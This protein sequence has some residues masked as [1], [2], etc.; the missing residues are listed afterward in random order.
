MTMT[1]D[2]HTPHHLPPATRHST[3]RSLWRGSLILGLISV[4]LVLAAQV[5][6]VGLKEQEQVTAP[7]DLWMDLL[8]GPPLVP[9]FNQAARG[10]DIA[11][12]DHW[13]QIS[14]L[15]G[16]SAGRKMVVF[17][18]AKEAEEQLPGLADQID[19]V[20]Y[21][22]EHGPGTPED[23]KADPV[24][25]IQRMR[26]LADAHGLVLALGPDHSFALSHGAAMAPYVDIF[27]LQIQQQ[28]TNPPVVID[29]IVPLVPQLRAANTTLQVSA[30]VRTE[31]DMGAIVELLD[32]LEGYLDGVSI[33]TS[34]QTV[35]VAEELVWMLRGTVVY[36]PQIVG[37]G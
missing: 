25:S 36:L 8:I 1:R 9:L 11:R 4:L 35:D 14:Q 15:S 27:V 37:D 17:K 16:I 7:R 2:Q 6:A 32:W 18:S 33:L 12:V 10:D 29:F 13:S 20:G 3:R 23:E 21:N 19:V 24:G 34:P 31:G 22:L 26:V 30:Q 28:Q 5:S